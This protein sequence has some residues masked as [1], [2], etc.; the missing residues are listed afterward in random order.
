MLSTLLLSIT[1]I[2]FRSFHCAKPEA[3]HLLKSIKQNSF[4]SLLSETIDA[5]YPML[6]EPQ[7]IALSVWLISPRM[8]CRDSSRLW[9]VFLPSSGR[10]TFHCMY[11]PPF[12]CPPVCSQTPLCSTF[13]QICTGRRKFMQLAEELVSPLVGCVSTVVMWSESLSSVSERHEWSYT[14]CVIWAR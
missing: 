8:H 3:R 10:I 6:Q 7:G 14:L 9:H 4:P 12:I 5:R 1:I 2:H 11:V 13:K